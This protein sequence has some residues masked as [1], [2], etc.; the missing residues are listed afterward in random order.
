MWE[1]PWELFQKSSISLRVFLTVLIVVSSNCRAWEEKST[2][3]LKVIQKGF[4]ITVC[5]KECLNFFSFLAS[6]SMFW[7]RWILLILPFLT[8]HERP[9]WVQHGH[10]SQSPNG[11]TISCIRSSS[12]QPHKLSRKRVAYRPKC[13]C[14]KKKLIYREGQNVEQNDGVNRLNSKTTV[15]H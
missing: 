7:L 10:L 11:L 13:R 1:L 4:K 9:I 12:S 15:V 3:L 5:L 6:V 8:V 2:I 14:L